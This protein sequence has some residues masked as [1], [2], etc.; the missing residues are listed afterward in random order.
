MPVYN[1]NWYE[2]RKSLSQSSAEGVAPLI[3]KLIPFRTVVDLGCGTGEWLAVLLQQGAED[4]LGIDGP[5]IE[6]D[7][8]TIP[9]SCFL[10]HNL[11]EPLTLDCRF[12]LAISLEAAEHVAPER[13]NIVV[14]NLVALAPVVLFSAAIPGQGGTGHV[15]EQWPGYWADKF[16]EHGYV[17]VDCF[18]RELWD[19]E[20]VAYWYAQNIVCYVQKE[21]LEDYPHVASALDPLRLHPLSLVHPRLFEAKADLSRQS[22]RRLLKA[23]LA[24]VRRSWRRKVGRL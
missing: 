12:D 4:L 15:N 24:A 14:D 8:L 19:M 17:W 16:R 7:M 20:G 11:G 2:S 22:S 5:W 13:A 10:S 21:K 18:R 9:K 3:Q 1:A 6:P 23:Y